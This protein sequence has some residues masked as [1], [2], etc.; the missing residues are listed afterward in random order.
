MVIFITKAA[1]IGEACET[2]T[3]CTTTTFDSQCTANV[4]EC[5]LPEAQLVHTDSET[6]MKYCYGFLAGETC[7]DHDE[8]LSECTSYSGKHSNNVDRLS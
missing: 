8:C 2:H 3:D 7:G 4:C 1:N 5:T 6:G